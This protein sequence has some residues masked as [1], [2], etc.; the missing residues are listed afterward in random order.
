[1]TR[2]QRVLRSS[3]H[4]A[5]SQFSHLGQRTNLFAQ[6]C[7]M[8]SQAITL[9]HTIMSTTSAHLMPPEQTT[10]NQVWQGRNL[11]KTRPWETP[12]IIS[13]F[14]NNA[15]QRLRGSHQASSFANDPFPAP[16]TKSR[17]AFLQLFFAVQPSETQR[18]LACLG[19]KQRQKNIDL[20]HLRCRAPSKTERFDSGPN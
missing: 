9:F 4:G 10:Y 15:R 5:S 11:I 3:A 13:D 18:Q 2:G 19:S 7:A 1:M 16:T 20:S 6:P 17:V 8:T 14:V 12:H